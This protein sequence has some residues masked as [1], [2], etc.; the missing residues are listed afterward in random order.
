MLNLSKVLLESTHESGLLGGGLESALSELGSGIDPLELS[1]LEISS[2]SVEPHGLSE[3]NNSLLDTGDG[4]LEDK[5]VVVDLTVSDETTHG[6]DGLGGSV[7]LGGTVGG[8]LTLANS[9]NLVVGGSSVVVTV[10]TGSSDGVLDVGRMPST[11]TGDLSETSMGLSGKLLGTPSMG[12]T[13]V[14]LTLGDGNGVDHLVLLENRGDVD[15]LLEVLSGKLDLVSDG[16]TVDLDLGEV[17][18]LLLKGSLLGLGVS[19]NSDNSTV[20]LDSLKLLG[21][22][23]GTALVLLS[24]LG[25]SGLLGLVPVL[26]E[27]SSDLL[28][29]VLGPDGGEGSKTSGGLDVA[30]NTDNNHGGSVD[31]GGG[32]NDLSLVHLGASSVEVSDNGGHTGLVTKESS[33]GNRLG[34]VIL[35]E[36]LGLSSGLGASL[37]GE[38]T[39]VTVS[40]LFVLSVGHFCLA[41][42]SIVRRT[43][44]R[45]LSLCEI[46]TIEFSSWV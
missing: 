43:Y 15:G 21:D 1:L 9:V 40:G 4:T 11:D 26:V 16:T 18:L 37:S 41:K 19:K 13:L 46:C 38:E 35:G 25:E 31:N 45:Y 6:G 42:V 5:E 33:E 29:K 39:Q 22:G 14:T 27:S 28:G 44:A 36:G 12:G 17:G 24:V 34:L 30:N 3:S 8:V 20:L 10:L 32:L 2:R 7:E 23:L